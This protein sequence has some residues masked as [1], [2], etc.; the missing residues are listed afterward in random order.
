[1]CGLYNFGES[2]EDVQ[3][4]TQL[5]RITSL[6][7]APF[8]AAADGSLIG[9]RQPVPSP[10]PEQ[11]SEWNAKFQDQ[12]DELC[13]LP[14][15]AHIGL[16]WP[17]FLLRLPYGAA[18]RPID[19]FAYEEMPLGIRVE[20]LL[21]GNPVIL[22]ACGIGQA[23]TEAGWELRLAQGREFRDLP[24]LT[25]RKDGETILHPCGEILLTDRAAEHLRRRGVTPVL[26]LKG[27]NAIRLPTLQSVRGTVLDES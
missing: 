9:C 7:Q 11:W 10:E 14:E 4:L 17:R 15:A 19:A 20:Q 12:W 2:D 13:R 16:L 3:L 5:A 22:A 1:L 27:Q 24:I 25:E 23:F 8:L 18:T 26:S 21:W 6:A